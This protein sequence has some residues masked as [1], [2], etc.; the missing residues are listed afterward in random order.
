METTATLNALPAL[1]SDPEIAAIVERER[2]RQ[3][4]GAE[5]IASENYT[6]DAV[7]AAQGSVLTN[8]YA[9][10]LPRKRYYGGC[11]FVDEAEQLAIDR[12]CQLFGAE[13]ANVQ[14]H[15]GASANAAVMLACL[16][17]GDTILGFDLAHGG[18]LT[19]GSPV[20]YS[21][22]LYRPTFY[23]VE[24]ETGRIDMDKV[25]E[26]AR[27]EKPQMIICGASAYARDWDYARFRAI[28]DEVGAVLLADIS[29][30][31][32]LIATGLLEN[33]LP[34]CH[35][36]TSTTHKTLRGPR[37]GIIM[38]GKDFPN[39]WGLTTMKGEV[40]SFTSLL[41]SGVFPGMQGGP[42]EHVIAGKA[43]AF[44]EA[45][46]PGYKSYCQQVVRNAQAMAGA[47]VDRGYHLISGGTDNHLMLID[48]SNKGV[49]G[50]AAETALGR[51]HITVNK[52][53][54]PFDTRSPFV[55]SG[56]RVGTP[57]VTTRGLVETDMVELV[58]WMDAVIQAPEDEAVLAR[59]GDAVRTK[60]SAYPLVG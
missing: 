7:M 39:P 19:H 41:D 42:L 29:H 54:V 17:P 10:G 45:L 50:K 1:V 35:V 53:M 8:K 14:P 31:A 22:K 40:R 47:F 36:V 46:Q 25:A 34:H 6:S 49:T 21:G 52:N 60:F 59:V 48:L 30:P 23:G 16:K 56:M 20:N 5:L 12:L 9:E 4:E 3:V 18:H 15:S 43:V 33:P 28:A 38:V 2:V 27:R 58:E 51:A 26:T 55:T 44:G 57:A 24:R 13:W 11:E 37:G 32:G